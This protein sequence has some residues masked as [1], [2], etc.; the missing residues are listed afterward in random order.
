MS[1]YLYCDASTAHHRNEIRDHV[2]SPKRITEVIKKIIS[3]VDQSKI[4]TKNSS[5]KATRED[6]EKI[7]DSDYVDDLLELDQIKQQIKFTEI[8]D[9]IFVNDYTLNAVLASAGMA[10]EASESIL[11]GKTDTA[12]V[13][14]RPP[15]HHAGYKK[16][17]GFCFV[18]N[19]CLV[20][21]KLSQTKKV[22]VFDWD[23]HFGDG[24]AEILNNMANT[25]FVSVQRHDN[26]TFY[27]ATGSTFSKNN[28][29]S[30]GFN[31]NITGHDYLKI[32]N[33][34]VLPLFEKFTPDVICISAGFDAARGDP[35]GLCKLDEED[36]VY[37][38][39]KLRKITPKILLC[40]EGGYDV[41]MMAS[42]I[43]SIIREL[44]K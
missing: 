31:G 16:P 42:C 30:I 44:T 38:I 3:D 7:H 29:H 13:L 26:G 19:I 9:D 43:V 20:V 32:F 11:Y 21:Q 35:L 36:Y 37:M 25:L 12:L 8:Y 41:D 24:S 17:K 22:A 39:S 15:G 2:E 18:N 28:I 33:Q 14:S 10:L 6:L 4:I 34:Q 5:R 40:L 1:L 23:V 27:P